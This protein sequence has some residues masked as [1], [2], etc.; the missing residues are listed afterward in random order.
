[1]ARLNFVGKSRKAYPDEGIPKGSPYYWWKH[2]YAAKQRSFTKPPRSR[3]TQ[4]AFKGTLWD[5]EDEIALAVVTPNMEARWEDWK[6]RIEELRQDC[7]D[8][9]ERM[10]EHLQQTSPTGELLQERI[11]ALEEWHS[12]LDAIAVADIC[13]TDYGNRADFLQDRDTADQD[14][15]ESIQETSCQ[16]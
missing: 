3:L 9:L 16:L 1:M 10:P 12:E 14:M 4:S 13:D 8:S 5:L 15:L 2:N 11:D 7:E 6:S